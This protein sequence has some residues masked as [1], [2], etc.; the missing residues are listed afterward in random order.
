MKRDLAQ[1]GSTEHDLLI[2]G[3]GIHGLAAAYDAAQRGLRVALV[4][5]GDF[6]SGASFN[7][8]K[9]VHGGLRYL[10]NADFPRMRE[11]ILE[12]RTMAR[13]APHLVRPQ[14][15]LI[16][17]YRSPTRSRTAM[18]VAFLVDAFIGRDRNGGL[19][20]SL[21]LPAGRTVG[22]NACVRLFPGVPA[23]GLTGGAIWHD[24]Q[25]QNSDRLTLAF[26]EAAAGQGAVAANYVEAVDA[27][28]K[29]GRVLGVRARDLLGGAELEVRARVT[30]NAAGSRA[31]P[32]MGAFGAPRSFLLIKAMNVVT[33]RPMDG[34]ALGA[35]SPDGR[36]LFMVPWRGRMMVGTAQSANPCAP[37]DTSVTDE[38]L[39]AFLTEIDGTF[40]ALQ[41]AREEITLVHRGGVPAVRCRDGRLDLQGHFEIVDHARDGVAGAV[42]VIGVKY[43]TARHVAQ[44]VVDV[45]AAKLSRPMAP[46]RTADLPLPGGETA[47]I[48]AL[49]REAT[50]AAGDALDPGTVRHLV[51]TYGTR[52]RAVL[53][54]AAEDCAWKER[55]EPSHPAVLAEVVHAVRDEMAQ[56]LTDVLIR[57]LPMGS[58]AYPG[59]EAARRAAAVM[60]QELGWSQ[61]RV[62]QE[63][64]GLA[65]FYAPIVVDGR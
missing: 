17:T 21:R 19:P 33:S 57:R 49:V 18:R 58:A 13:L 6:G 62:E 14:G 34:L 1:L 61:A 35:R 65:A 5:R 25:M 26:A 64:E 24:Y 50:A 59:H 3:G 11:S 60:Q 4:E 27:I 47:D 30:L 56:T 10:Q 40:P 39:R 41:L 8:L 28:R 63:L 36:V 7:H 44:A 37:E 46:C 12:R 38:E 43:T 45:V 29:D 53:A 9:T 31:G 2:V 20:P 16:G 32:V 55:I 15:F 52:Y 23:D 54:V 42:S 22:R 51:E 48:D